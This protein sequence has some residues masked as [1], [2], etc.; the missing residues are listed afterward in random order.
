MHVSD[1]VNGDVSLAN[2]IATSCVQLA[3][4]LI[5]SVTCRNGP[6]KTDS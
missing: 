4:T 1:L 5:I 6:N 2:A 3:T